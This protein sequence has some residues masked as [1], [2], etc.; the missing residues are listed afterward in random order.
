M[1]APAPTLPLEQIDTDS[2]NSSATST[3]LSGTGLIVARGLTASVIGASVILFIIA[4]VYGLAN[5]LESSILP[6]SAAEPLARVGLSIPALTIMMNVVD[7]VTT[8]VFVGVALVIFAT[9]SSD[10]ATLLAAAMLTTWGMSTGNLLAGA[11]GLGVGITVGVLLVGM[12]GS[13]TFLWFMYTAPTGKIAPSWTR[14]LLWFWVLGW[15]ALVLYDYASG[16][17]I[18]GEMTVLSVLAQAAMYTISIFVIRWRV[19]NILTPTQ[20]QQFK[21]VVLGLTF[22]LIGF[23]VRFIPPLT[24][25]ALSDTSTLLGLGFVSISYTF[26]RICLTFVPIMIGFS[27]MRYRLWDVDFMINRSL[28]YG[29]VGVFLIVGAIIEIAGVIWFTNLVLGQGQALIAVALAGAFWGATFN[30]LRKWMQRTI[31]KNLYGIDL[32]YQRARQVSPLSG[33]QV[34]GQK[35]GPYEVLEPIG[36]GGMAEVYKGYHATLNRLVAIKVLAP[37][38]VSNAD[39]RLRF[40]REAQMV[41]ALRHPHVVQVFDFGDMEDTYYMVMEY[42]AGPT[43]S[44]YI[45][46]HGRLSL[47]EGLPILRQIASALDYAH[48]QGLVHRDVKPSNVMLQ[49]VTTV[50]EDGIDKRAILTDFGIAKIRGGHT[51]LTQTGMMGT[52]DYIAPEQIQSSKT[53]DARADIYALGVMAFQMLTGELPFKGDNPGAL[54]ISHLQHPAPDPRAIVPELPRPIARAILQALEKSPDKRFATAEDFAE[55]LVVAE[56]RVVA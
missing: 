36:R 10:G 49:P 47:D 13:I 50:D 52:L 19:Y 42:I 33:P 46:T 9:R 54:L 23:M 4:A 24:V 55:A 11:A 51:G 28:V 27:L 2:Q 37:N 26:M 22:A 14:Y 53:V 17:Y 7:I 12:I 48:Q 25:P 15:T 29:G 38:L 3:E 41:A 40:E 43:L 30:P 45:K 8:A 5:P 18:T 34:M 20:L 44:S 56:L 39:F 16:G 31:D 1:S 32:D 21:W 35:F 6:A